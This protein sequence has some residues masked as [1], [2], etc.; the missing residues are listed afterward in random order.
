MSDVEI[1][2]ISVKSQQP[3]VQNDKRYVLP[4]GSTRALDHNRNFVL[5]VR[6]ELF[7]LFHDVYELDKE[8]DRFG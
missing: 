1:M 7:E 5:T 6:E 4:D 8:D 2:M 3:Q